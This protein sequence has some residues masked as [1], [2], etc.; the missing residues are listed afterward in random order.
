LDTH[1]IG[2]YHFSSLLHIFL[3][4]PQEEEYMCHGYNTTKNLQKE[5]EKK[6]YKISF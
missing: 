3:V 4:E 5:K 6:E 2:A 1:D